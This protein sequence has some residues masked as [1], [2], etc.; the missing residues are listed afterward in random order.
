[1][2]LYISSSKGAISM[3][4]CRRLRFNL[5]L[6]QLSWQKSDISGVN[7]VPEFGRVCFLF[8]C[9]FFCP[10]VC[11]ILHFWTHSPQLRK[12]SRVYLCERCVCVPR[13][14]RRKEPFNVKNPLSGSALWCGAVIE[15][16]NR[17]KCCTCTE[18]PGFKSSLIV[19]ELC[20]Q[21]KLKINY[22]PWNHV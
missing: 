19:L 18:F 21:T 15:R 6:I 16:R 1:M 9:L 13:I 20:W 17:W 14:A 22:E 8:S 3:I 10:W 12:V 11:N 2:L 4:L 7:F 5:K